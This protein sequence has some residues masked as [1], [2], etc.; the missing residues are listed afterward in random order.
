MGNPQHLDWLLEGVEVWNARR[1]EDNFEPDLSN[2]D[3]RK[4]F[5]EA[6]KLNK[7]GRIPL[8]NR[9]PQRGEHL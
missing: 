4:A 6:G 3:I 1:G 8:E 2:F 5:E 7:F 9:E